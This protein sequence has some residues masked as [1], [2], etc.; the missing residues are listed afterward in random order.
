MTAAA[1]ILSPD[2]NWTPL[3]ALDPAEELPQPAANAIAAVSVTRRVWRERIPRRYQRASSQRLRP[4][5][6]L[7]PVSTIRGSRVPGSALLG[8][9][10]VQPAAEIRSAEHTS[11]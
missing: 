6:R 4:F 11:E 1:T 2:F 10:A 3:N 9:A 5:A 8:N 7:I